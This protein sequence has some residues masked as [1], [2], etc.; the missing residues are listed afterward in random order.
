VL[1]KEGYSGVKTGFTP[2]AGNCLCSRKT[3]VHKQVRYDLILVILGC[4]TTEDRF[5][6]TVAI[7]E[8]FLRYL[9]SMEM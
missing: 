1:L 3:I 5:L 4:R 2:T 7:V 8:D 9:R 6:E